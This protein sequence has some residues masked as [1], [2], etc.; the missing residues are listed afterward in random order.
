MP[1][2]APAGIQE[3]PPI[4]KERFVF[5]GTKA[6]IIAFV[7]AIVAPGLTTSGAHRPETLGDRAV[8]VAQL[9]RPVTLPVPASCPTSEFTRIDELI[10]F[11]PVDHGEIVDPDA[12]IRYELV[13]TAVAEVLVPAVAR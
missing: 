13:H 3:N 9:T 4:H 11:L 5:E 10:P 1:A 7:A 8:T 12:P 6:L 2:V